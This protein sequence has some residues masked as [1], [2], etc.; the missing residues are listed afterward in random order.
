MPFATTQWSVVLDAQSELRAAREAMEKLCRIYWR[1]IYSFVQRQGIAPKEAE[2]FTQGF[3]ALLL[4]RKDLATVRKKKGRLRSYLLASV[5]NFLADERRSAMAIKRGKGER[6]IACEEIREHEHV[7]VERRDRL[8]AEQIY[9]RRWALTVLEQVLTRLRD[10]YRS[11]GN[12]R[13]FDQSKKMLMDEP[14]R[15]SRA[16]VASEFGMTE[17]AIK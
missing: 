1:S 3:F 7:N 9:E 6:L 15:L 10:E 2:D 13:F 12:V 17:K 11:A 14:D 8:P 5:K 4:E 16:Q